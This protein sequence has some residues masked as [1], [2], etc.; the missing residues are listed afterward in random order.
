MLKRMKNHTALNTDVMSNH[1]TDRE[2][3][4]KRK[5]RKWYRGFV[6]LLVYITDGVYMK[7]YKEKV[8]VYVW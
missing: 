8:F 3:K 1:I 2:K 7:I 5:E 6:L 4:R